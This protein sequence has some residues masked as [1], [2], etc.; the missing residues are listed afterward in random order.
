M[1]A[2][3]RFRSIARGRAISVTPRSR[4]Y[5]GDFGA[6]AVGLST[7]VALDIIGSDGG[8][9][10]A[11]FAV[12]AISHGCQPIHSWIAQPRHQDRSLCS[13]LLGSRRID[14]FRG[15]ILWRHTCPAGSS[16]TLAFVGHDGR[17]GLRVPTPFCSPIGKVKPPLGLQL[18]SASGAERSCLEGATK[19]YFDR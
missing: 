11:P 12:R 10:F 17:A 19:L 1:S 5:F 6:A 4:E 9:R 16:V 14:L 3:C 18:K 2:R 13:L 8:R 7:G 15:T